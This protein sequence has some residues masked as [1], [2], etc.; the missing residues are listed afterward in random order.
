MTNFEK[1]AIAKVAAELIG[2][3]N[4]SLSKGSDVRYG[5]H[6]SLSVDTEK[7]TYF[8]HEANEGGG[9]I[10]LVCRKN[11]CSKF[12]AAQWLIE[13]GYMQDQ[14]AQQPRQ[15]ATY[16]YNDV[17]GVM[18]FQVV[19]YQPKTFKQRKPEGAGWSWS[20]KGVEQVPYKLPQLLAQPDAVVFVAEGEKDCDRLASIGLVATCNAGGAGKWLSAGTSPAATR[21]C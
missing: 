5:T 11:D 3:P 4:Q 1:N 9:I 16:D 10:D 20:V 7:N 2:E 12:E 15:V 8:D 6:G 19:R 14:P 17:D 18:L 13:R 21:T